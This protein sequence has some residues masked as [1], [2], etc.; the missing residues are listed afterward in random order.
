MWVGGGKGGGA[1]RWCRCGVPSTADQDA[2]FCKTWYPTLGGHAETGHVAALC[3]HA[4]CVY[5]DPSDPSVMG[6]CCG[7]ARLR[8]PLMQRWMGMANLNSVSMFVNES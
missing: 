7:V 2:R 3:S 8:V 4:F 1:L 5:Q 6:Q